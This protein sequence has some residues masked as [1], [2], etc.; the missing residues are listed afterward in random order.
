MQ[1]PTTNATINDT[2]LRDGEQSA[3]VSFTLQEK[4][5]IARSLDELGVPELEVG[6]P[7]MG[8]EEREAIRAV[9][10]SVDNARLMVWCRMYSEDIGLCGNL[11]V[12]MVDLS[13]P[14]SDQQIGKKLGRSREW[15]LA[16]IA[17]C[18]AEAHEL[19]LEVCVGGEDASRADPAFLWQVVEAAERAGARRF[20]FADTVGIMEPFQVYD[21]I[22]D[23][24]AMSD[25]EIEMHAHDDLGLATANT[26][27][28]IR[29]GATHANTTVHGLGERAGN[30]PLEEV[31]MGLRRFHDQGHEIDMT[32]YSL[33]SRLVERASGR[34]VGWQKS[35]VGAGVFTHEAGIHVD[36]LMKDRRNYQGVDPAELGRD[37]EF[38]LGKHSGSHAV[39]QA[40]A[41]MGMALSRAQAETLLLLVRRHAVENKRPP[42]A[43]DLRRFYLEI[44][45]GNREWMRQ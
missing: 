11:G 40:Y 41:D 20:R 2:T 44:Y 42:A 6:I 33:L 18:V 17:P 25:I 7:A 15:V 26:L 21:A 24:R 8:E 35:L 30:A 16:Q 43:R 5:A 12:Q 31:V 23:L 22:R 45:S 32:R 27:A 38:V 34:S 4:L 37:H 3:G 13:M 10:A 36:G 9:A 19:G 1:Q 29:G 28:A 39:I 14:V